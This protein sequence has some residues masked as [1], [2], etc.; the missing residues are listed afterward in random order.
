MLIH[1]SSQAA[2]TQGEIRTTP[3][4][5]FPRTSRAPLR[6]IS[7][8]PQTLHDDDIDMEPRRKRPTSIAPGEQNIA[9]SSNP[10]S[11]KSLPA[12]IR[13]SGEISESDNKAEAKLGFPRR[14]N[15]FSFENCAWKKHANRDT[16]VN[17]PEISI[18][19]HPHGISAT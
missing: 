12:R 1:P 2:E 17:F 3:L 13:K 8:R 10:R 5:N 11:I 9:T 14:P 16:S 7:P 4:P 19:L 6:E 18:P 15:F